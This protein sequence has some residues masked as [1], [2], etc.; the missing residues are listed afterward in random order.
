MIVGLAHVLHDA[1]AAPAVGRELVVA[2]LADDAETVGVVDVEERVVLTR[3]PGKLWEG[4]RVPSHAV[5]AVDADQPRHRPS[6]P[7]QPLEIIRV[8]ELEPPHGRAA[9]TG[10]L[11]ALI[12]RLVRP[13][14]DV[15]RPRPG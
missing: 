11:A 13:R 12:D 9:G 15:D 8:F 4:D 10:K 7:E 14:L 2:P 1:V 5:H 3:E 6:V